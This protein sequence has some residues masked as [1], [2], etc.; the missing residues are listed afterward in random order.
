MKTP[1]PQVVI[2]RK[3]G[4]NPKRT[5]NTLKATGLGFLL[6]MFFVSSVV[7]VSVYVSVLCR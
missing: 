1:N 7:S 5:Q 3:T 6:K 2:L 4:L